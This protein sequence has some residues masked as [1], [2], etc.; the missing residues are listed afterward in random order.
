[1]DFTKQFWV[2]RLGLRWTV[3][4]QDTLKSDYMKKLMGF[5]NTEYALNDVVPQRKDVFKPFSV[6]PF[7]DVK[8]VIIGLDPS[9]INRASGLWVGDAGI[10][11]TYPPLRLY[12]LRR[13]VEKDYG[14]QIDFDFSLESWGRQGVLLLNRALTAR[15]GII[16]SHLR[17]WDKFT[18]AVID[19]LNQYNPGTIFILYDEAQ[20]LKSIISNNHEVMLVEYQK[21]F[22]DV[23]EHY[24]SQFKKCNDLLIAKYGKGINW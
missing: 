22:G 12:D 4:L 13:M 18:T 16:E 5:L 23:E 1:M 19:V 7:E 20:E 6:C 11:G 14:L 17:P 15:R 21:D 9:L 2:D 10:T 24:E 8:V 3:L